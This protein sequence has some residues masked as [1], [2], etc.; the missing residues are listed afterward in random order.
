V[1]FPGLE[2]DHFI[3]EAENPQVEPE[4]FVLACRKCNRGK[5]TRHPLAWAW[6]KGDLG[7][8]P[9]DSGGLPPEQGTGNREGK[10]T[11]S[12]PAT[13]RALPNPDFERFWQQYP[14]KVD[15]KLA[16]TRFGAA[17]KN[18]GVDAVV[19]GLDRWCAYWRADRTE[20]KH[21]PHPPVWLSKE[22]FLADPPRARGARPAQLSQNGELMA[23]GVQF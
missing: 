9:E 23:P 15:K 8:I 7:N 10:T 20:E 12:P 21:I 14:R 22:R 6:R 11:T 19:S 1:T 2:I 3:P 17:V 13:L 5:G 16:E 18:H 4:N